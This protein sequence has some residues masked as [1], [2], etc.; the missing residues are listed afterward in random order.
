MNLIGQRFGRLE[1]LEGAGTDRYQKTIWLCQCDCG[2]TK[3]ILG[4]NLKSGNT[5]SC[6]CYH[7]ESTIARSVTHNLHHTRLYK[8]WCDMKK[9]CDNPRNKSYKY[10]GGRGIC[11]CDEWKEFESFN[12]WAF[13][14]GYDEN[15]PRW[16]CTI[17]RI[18]N[19]S[20]YEPLNC[21]WVTMEVQ[22]NNKRHRSA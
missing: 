12:R 19:D 1:V 3:I 18:D 17:D 4:A 22:N 15:A 21:R 6:G 9:R 20:N 14:N 5:T 10:Y 16:E 2:N 8:V 13:D 7:K 11:V